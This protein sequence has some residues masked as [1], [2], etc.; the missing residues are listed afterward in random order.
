MGYYQAFA[1][2]ASCGLPFGFNPHLVPS[3][4]R[5][6]E[7]PREPI[8]RGCVE[9]ANPV[10]RERGLDEI[11]VLPGAYEPAAEGPEG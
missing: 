7:G 10:R 4:R 2:C 9:R 3:V 11:R 5:T 6:P 8:C 1:P